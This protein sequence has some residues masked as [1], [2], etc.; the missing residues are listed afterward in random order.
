MEKLHKMFFGHKVL[1]SNLMS[2]AK[3]VC[4]FLLV[5]GGSIQTLSAETSKEASVQQQSKKVTG[6]VTDEN[7]EPLIGVTITLKGQ[8]KGTVTDVD[9]KFSLEV[10]NSAVLVVSY[11]G[12]KRQFVDYKGQTVLDI[13][14]ESD[15]EKLNEVVVIGY[16]SQKIKNVSGSIAPVDMQKVDAIP[17]SNLIDALSGQI[18][19]MSVTAAGSR[20]G[21]N[22]AK[23][24]I[25]QTF[26]FSKD[27]GST[28]PLVVIDDVIQIDPSTGLPS[29]DKFSRLD[30]SEIES[31]T[32]LRDASAA[33]YGSRAS[34]GAI[35]IKTKRGK[36]G[37]AKVSYSGKFEWNDAVSHEKVTNAYETGLIANSILRADGKTAANL[38]SDAELEQMKSLDYNWLDKAWKGAGAMNHSVNVNGGSNKATYFAGASMYT[39]GANLGNQDYR[40]YNFRAGTDVNLTNSLKLTATIDAM[41]SKQEK[42][43]T[44]LGNISDSS[45][46]SA[47][48]GEQADYTYLLHMPSHIPWSY[49]IGGADYWVSPALGPHAV[50]STQNTAN[51]IGAWN[52]FGLLEN[53]S[54]STSDN[55]S[56]GV[57]F[58]LQYSVPYVKG[59]SVKATYALNRASNNAEQMQLPYI[60]AR[61]KYTNNADKHLYSSTVDSDWDIAQ[62]NKNARVLY[63][64][65][66]SQSEQMNLYVNYDHKFGQHNIS[67]VASVERAEGKSEFSRLYYESPIIGTY[68]G[69]SSSAGTLSPSF[70]YMSKAE[71]AKMS[72]LGRISYDYAGKYL[73]Q[74]ILRSD[75]STNFAPEH[76]WGIFPSISLGWVISE[77]NWFK[78]H[79]KWIDYLKL[80]GSVGKTGKD[81]VKPWKWIQLYDYYADKGLGFGTNGGNYVS[82]VVPSVTPYRDITWDTS[83]K[84]NVGIDV[85]TLNNRLA[86]N[87]DGYF[88]HTTN[89]LTNMAGSSGVAISIG[90]AFA[91][92]NYSAIDAWGLEFSASWKDKIGDVRYSVGV[93]TGLSWNK[94]LKYVEVGN[95]YVS[96][97]SNKAGYSTIRPKY[98]YKVWKGNSTGDGLLRNQADVDAYWNYLTEHAT[99]A[100]TTPS[101][102]G[103]TSKAS[104]KPGMLAYQ[105]LGGDLQADG[106]TGIPNGQIVDN[107]QDLA[108]MNNRNISYGFNTNLGLSWKNLSW[109]AQISTSWGEY[110]S[111]DVI[112]QSTGSGRIIWARESFWRD[113][114]DETTN[115]NG[116]YPNI[117]YSN[118]K[119]T[120]DFWRVS[121]FRCYVRNMNI[122]Y[123][124][125]KKLIAK[126]GIESAK[127]SLSG[128]NLWDFFNPYP[129][130]Y[131]NMYDDSTSKYPTLRTWAL[132]VNL[133]F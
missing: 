6:T 91:E 77:E 88:D 37:T 15:V 126:L 51:A 49:N 71:N 99:V 2:C 46:G 87:F 73:A 23:I 110:N 14:M 39:Q 122:A 21:S 59:L 84:Y 102:F 68:N 132:G 18:P 47:G 19:G 32:V 16:G 63:D 54:K 120:S 65:G 7:G 95:D 28:N 109:N 105:D 44:K 107:G 115:P 100:G 79:V 35:V 116:K 128:N 70:T 48:A 121:S 36:E 125:P 10:P 8:A 108:K 118:N 29:M 81:N 45:Y 11:V 20:P 114:F 31:M 89:M 34:Q 25:R 92:Q 60:L 127:F 111:I 75:A 98:A 33:I 67:A 58:S 62:N 130:H 76:Y 52:Y 4:C 17:T 5:F 40:R 50:T 86:L 56:Y 131:R 97:I 101:Y 94:L 42:S 53:G 93:N 80:R 55:F 41:N 9:G 26:D 74:F 72:Y 83:I 103:I 90:G 3:W 69:A 22:D 104:M 43:Y 106:S 124:V 27:G 113:M 78:N 119:V 61:A 30:P 57:N 129:N 12:Y 66:T 123:T 133:T 85:N 96:N 1:Q 38:Y 117:Y 82:G 112:G 13:K 24:E 64:K